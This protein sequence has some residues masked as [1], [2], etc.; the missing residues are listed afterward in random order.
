MRVFPTIERN[1]FFSSF[2]N[3]SLKNIKSQ[4]EIIYNVYIYNAKLNKA[5][6]RKRYNIAKTYTKLAKHIHVYETHYKVEQTFQQKCYSD[7]VELQ[8]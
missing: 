3:V 6:L 4:C 7:Q 1:S 8:N 2:L 5:N